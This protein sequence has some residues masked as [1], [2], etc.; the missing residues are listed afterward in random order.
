MRLSS[1]GSL[2]FVTTVEH[3]APTGEG[4]LWVVDARARRVLAQVPVGAAPSDVVVL[5]DNSRAYVVNNAGSSVSVVDLS[6]FTVAATVAVQGSPSRAVVTPTGTLCMSR[7]RR[8]TPSRRSR[9]RINSVEATLFVGASPGGIDISPDG[10][11]VF[12]AN[13]GSQTVSVID[14]ALDSVLRSLAAG[15][16]S[17]APPIDVSAPSSTRAFVTLSDTSGSG[18][19]AVQ[20]LNAADGAVLG[21]SSIRAGGRLARDSSGTPTYVVDS[22]VKLVAADGTSVTTLV[23]GAWTA[24]AVLTDPCA[25][26]ATVSPATFGPLGGSGTLTIPAPAGCPWSIETTLATG[27]SF[28]GA[29]T[30]TGSATR[31]FS[32]EAADAPKLGTVVIGRQTLTLEQT[33]PRMVIESPT[34]G[35]GLL[36][37]PFFLSGWAI[38]QNL[39]AK[40]VAPRLTRYRCRSCLGVPGNRFADNRSVADF[41]RVGQRGVIQARRCGAVRSQRPVQ[42]LPH[43]D[44]HAAVR[45]LHAGRVRP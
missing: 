9:R 34:S 30:G 39:W 18:G 4:R 44:Q 14:A 32:V 1:D 29:L 10:S 6:A 36:Q 45:P 23:E 3:L 43:P 15:S 35:A 42:R 2:L 20:L 17:S 26:E 19:S 27:F 12:V 22:T 11:R 31:A 33:I 25:F 7:T 16:F 38:D 8:R 37:E 13:A 40:Y 5:P 21:S 24:A 41:R 28:A